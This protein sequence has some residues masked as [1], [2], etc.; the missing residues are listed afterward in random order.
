MQK[1]SHGSCR[2]RL[3]V[4]LRLSERSA[5]SVENINAGDGVIKLCDGALR[6]KGIKHK[7]GVTVFCAAGGE[8]YIQ[9][10]ALTVCVGAER[11]DVWLQ[12]AFHL[13]FLLVE[14]GDDNAFARK[15][16]R[17]P[18]AEIAGRKAVAGKSNIIDG[19]SYSGVLFHRLTDGV[20]VYAGGQTLVYPALDLIERHIL[21]QL[22]VDRF[23]KSG[24]AQRK[25]EGKGEKGTGIKA[26]GIPK[27]YAGAADAPFKAAHQIKMGNINGRAALFKKHSN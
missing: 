1:A 2:G 21:Y 25:G 7:R 14:L 16:V 15:E 13:L 3:S 27:R 24:D 9:A 8:G 5:V 17:E 11:F 10:N 26:L 20:Y 23:V 12:V 19:C 18:G 6:G 4:F 22:K